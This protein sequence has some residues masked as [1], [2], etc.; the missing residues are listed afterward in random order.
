M[1]NRKTKRN[2]EDDVDDKHKEKTK[3]MC[4]YYCINHKSKEICSIYECNGQ[5]YKNLDSKYESELKK[6]SYIN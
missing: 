4:D 1:E 2:H 3:K 5:I 6:D